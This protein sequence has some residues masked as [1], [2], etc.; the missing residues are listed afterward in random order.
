[1]A[2]N[3]DTIVIL[4]FGSQTTQ[5]IARKIREKKVHAEIIPFD[6]PAS[7]IK[8]MQPKGIIFSGGPAGLY[9]EDAPRPDSRVFELGVPILG[10]CYGLQ[11][12]TEHFEGEVV[13]GDKNKEYGEARLSLSR[14][15][16]SPLLKDVPEEEGTVWMSHGDEVAK[17]PKDFEVLGKTKDSPYAIIANETK[18]IF[19][20]QFHP[21]V[22]QTQCGVQ[23]L[24]NFAVGIAQAKREWDPQ[25]IVQGMVDEVRKTVGDKKVLHAISGGV[26]STVMAAILHEAIGDKLRC[27]MVDT[28]FLRKGEVERSCD[29]FKKYLKAEVEIIDAKERFIAKLEGVVDGQERRKIIGREYIEIFQGLLGPTDL[30][31]QGTLYPDVIESAV[32]VN[33]PAHTIKTHHNRAPEVIELMKQGRVIEIFKDLFKD[34]VRAIGEELGLPKEIVWRQPFP[35][36]GLAIRILGEITPERLETLRDADEIVTEELKAS[37]LYY[38]IAQ[39]VVALDSHQVTCVKGDGKALGYLIFIRNVATADFMTVSPFDVPAELRRKIAT[40]ILNE[41]R[42]AGR[43]LFDE[44]TKPPA[45]ICY[46]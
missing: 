27:V 5:L 35:G 22:T 8:K 31:S 34:E 45:T 12:I 29:R 13:K 6:T 14:E 44:S 28:G 25:N 3:P 1:M 15:K 30:L 19:A 33:A 40:R 11:L 36:P 21:E 9:E 24:E 26:D 39:T 7:E 42:G 10:L 23:I 38:K 18:Q 37:D 16:K 32:D 41:V 4:N 20:V 17:M 2:K 43:V 46:L